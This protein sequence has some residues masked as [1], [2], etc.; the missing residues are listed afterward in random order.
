[1]LGKEDR[2]QAHH[3][4]SPAGLPDIP[5]AEHTRAVITFAEAE[6]WDMVANGKGTQAQVK[7]TTTSTGKGTTSGKK[8]TDNPKTD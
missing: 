2:V 3:F 7:A 5:T 1:M 4:A 8:G 6:L